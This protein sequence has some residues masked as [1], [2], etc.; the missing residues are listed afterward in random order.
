MEPNP[1]EWATTPAEPAMSMP[2]PTRQRAGG[3]WRRTAAYLFDFILIELIFIFFLTIGAVAVNIASAHDLGLEI[4]DPF[5]M[6]SAGSFMSLWTG[7][8]LLY[9]TFFTYWGGKTPGKMLMRLCVVTQ[10]L[11]ELTLLRAFVRSFFSCLSLVLGLGLVF[12]IAAFDHKK[13]ALHDFIVKTY[14]VRV[15]SQDSI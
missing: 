11:G 4:L 13:R 5:L 8:F 6:T 3:F 12:I 2:V 10:D 9:F 1:S 14:V 7:L 15:P